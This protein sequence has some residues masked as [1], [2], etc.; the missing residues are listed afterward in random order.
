VIK[1]LGGVDCIGVDITGTMG[2]SL[3]SQGGMSELK[4]HIT[5]ADG[6]YDIVGPFRNRYHW[7]GERWLDWRKPRGFEGPFR[8][9][10]EAEWPIKIGTGSITIE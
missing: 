7:Q 3:L 4:V 5:N 1:R 6:S 10:V 2:E 9:E 8:V